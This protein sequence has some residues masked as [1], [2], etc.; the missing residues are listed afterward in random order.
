MISDLVSMAKEANN[1]ENSEHIEVL[2]K[3]S[4]TESLERDTFRRYL[5][6]SR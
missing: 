4:I 2:L 1:S 5:V 6:G 3:K